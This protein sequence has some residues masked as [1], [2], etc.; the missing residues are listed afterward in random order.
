ME[1]IK[2]IN[3]LEKV[4]VH[5]IVFKETKDTDWVEHAY[6]MLSDVVEELK[7]DKPI[8]DTVQLYLSQREKLIID[9]I[10]NSNPETLQAIRDIDRYALDRFEKDGNGWA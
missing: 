10:K 5:L 8:T 6:N 4:L 7:G 9:Y 3:E 1:K 2:L